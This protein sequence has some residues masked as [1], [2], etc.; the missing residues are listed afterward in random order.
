[1]PGVYVYAHA[2]LRWRWR[3]GIG[4]VWQLQAVNLYADIARV[5]SVVDLVCDIKG[6]VIAGA[7]AQGYVDAELMRER[8]ADGSAECVEVSAERCQGVIGTE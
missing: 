7:V 2:S 4:Q 3:R 5:G 8:V 1:M 6:I